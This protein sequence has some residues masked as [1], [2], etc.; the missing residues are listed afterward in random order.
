MAG[1]VEDLDPP[2]V[3]E[4]DRLTAAQPQVDRRVASAGCLQLR[5]TQLV[6]LVEAVRLVP[7][8]VLVDERVVRLDPA[9]VELVAGET[10]TGMQVAQRA[11]AARV[12]EVGV[13]DQHVVERL[14]A[15]PH[16]LE[17]RAQHP[18]RRIGHAGVEQQ[19]ASVS[20]EHV[21]RHEAHSEGRLDAVNSR[22]DLHGHC[23]LGSVREP[24]VIVYPPSTR[25]ISPVT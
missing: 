22:C 3:A 14:E 23:L 12:V 4:P 8:V 2:V 15:E 13:A 18:G 21:L 20:G 10:R 1:E 24:R 16:G 7:Q 5:A 19:R 25:R 9:P 6:G 17:I 11:V